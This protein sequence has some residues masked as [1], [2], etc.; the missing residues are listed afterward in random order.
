[1][2]KRIIEIDDEKINVTEAARILRMAP[3]G[4][5][6]ALRKGKFNYF[7]EAWKEDDNINWYYY[8]NSNRFLEYVGM[9]ATRGVDLPEIQNYLQK[10]MQE[11]SHPESFSTSEKKNLEK[12]I[13]KLKAENKKL[14]NALNRIMEEASQIATD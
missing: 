2:T 12:E 14:K 4:L 3:E 10:K 5:R 1:M 11:A 7:G 9:A 6:A 13:K 8:I